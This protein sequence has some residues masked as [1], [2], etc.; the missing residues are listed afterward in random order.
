MPELREAV[1]RACELKL[2]ALC[3][4]GNAVTLWGLAEECAAAALAAI[5][6]SGWVLTPAE[7]TGEQLAAVIPFPEHLRARYPAEHP[8]HQQMWAATAAERLAFR[9]RYMD[10]LAARPRDAAPTEKVEDHG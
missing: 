8:W 7:P 3:E 1:R 10:A 5:E 9:Q 2:N 6:A 4:P